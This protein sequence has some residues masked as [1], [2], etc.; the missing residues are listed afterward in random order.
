MAAPTGFVVFMSPVPV[1][2]QESLSK[3]L[4]PLL[5][6]LGIVDWDCSKG[7]DKKFAFLTFLS[8]EDGL[9]FLRQHGQRP[10]PGSSSRA[11]PNLRLLDRP[12]YCK[13]GDK[14]PDSLVVRVLLK[15]AHDRKRAREDTDQ[16]SSN[17]PVV[18]LKIAGISCG[19]YD[20][21]DGNLE[22]IQDVKWSV[23]EAAA[24]FS[25]DTLV[26]TFTTSRV[27]RRVEFAYRT[28]HEI[29]V[30]DRPPC[31]LLTLWE[32]PRMF[33]ELF[34]PGQF[35]HGAVRRK[36]VNSMCDDSSDHEAVVGQSAVYCITLEWEQLVSNLARLKRFEHLNFT[37]CC[38]PI[39]AIAH[40]PMLAGLRS[41]KATLDQ[42]S[43]VMPFDI[44]FQLQALVNNGYVLPHTAEKLLR[45][46]FDHAHRTAPAR[47]CE[48]KSD[49]SYPI[50][51]ES[52]KK[53]FS[54]MPF[55]GP[56]AEAKMFEVDEIWSWLEAN[57]KDFRK[58]L[59]RN[60]LSERARQNLTMI[61]RVQV[62]PSR[63]ILTGPEPEAKNRIL[64]KFP[65]HTDYFTRV[66]FCD[67]DGQDV[68]YNPRVSLDLVYD[69]FTKVLSD[70]FPIA[71]RL[72]KYL[73]YSHSSLR[74]HAAWH[75]AVFVDDDG[76]LQSYLSVIKDLGN[77]EGIRSP[78]KWKG[79]RAEAYSYYHTGAARIGQAFSE[80]PSAVDLVAVNAQ[81][82]AIPDVESPD[83]RRVFSD[84]VGT[85]SR[86]LLE[87]IHD[88]MPNKS[89]SATC[90]QI[91]WAGAKG[92]LSLD[93]TLSGKLM[94]IRPSMMKF[95]SLDVRYLEICDAA[96]KPIPLVLN[97]QMIKILEDMGCPAEWF[98]RAQN[99]ELDRLKRVTMSTRNTATFLRRQKIAEQIPLHTLLRRLDR[100]GFDYKQDR[101]LCSVVETVVLREVRLLKHKSRIPIEQGVTLFGVMDEFGFLE[102]DD[103]YVTLDDSPGR[104]CPVLHNRLV[105]ITRSPALHPGDIQIRRAVVPPPHH[106]LC[107]LSNCV[108]FSQKGERDLPSQLSGG[109][110]DGDIYNIIWDAFAV[111]GCRYEYPPADYPR[112]TALDI[113]RP[114]EQKDIIDNFVGF[115]K[116]DRLGF[117]ATRHVILADYHDA[118]TRHSDCLKLAEM[119]STAVDYS[120]TGIPVDMSEMSQ[121]YNLR[122]RPDFLAPAPP[123]IIMDRSD[124]CFE[125]PTAQSSQEDEDDDSGPKHKYYMSEKVLGTLYRAIDE[126]R[127]W[128]DNIHLTIKRSGISLWDEVLDYVHDQCSQL[129]QV[130]WRN[131][132]DEA[133]SIRQAYEDMI[134]SA[135]I[136]FS[137]HASK[138][139]TELEVFTGAIHNRTGIQTRRQRDTS[140]RLKDEFDRIT[141]WVNGLMRGQEPGELA[142]EGD[143]DDD[144]NDNDNDEVEGD[145]S[146]N[147]GHGEEEH[148]HDHDHVGPG[149]M[150]MQQNNKR[151]TALERSVACLSVGLRDLEEP[152]GGQFRAGSSGRFDSFKV[153]AAHN[154]LRE[155]EAETRRRES[156]VDEGF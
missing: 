96:N 23:L 50:S 100:L 63:I 30:S 139:I 80:T 21:P 94:R 120:K 6:S 152:G 148:D 135:T 151:C 99:R 4:S 145:R 81:Y 93:D 86:D 104:P 40:C 114:V 9:R 97:R 95:Q 66:Q 127:I 136:D 106:P 117:I 38:V 155:L 26:V 79:R 13:E 12:V 84:G 110:L 143:G 48:S 25:R 137:E 7:K 51:A 15:Q 39:N 133:W 122:A 65:R 113:G 45:R 22:Y 52:L 17:T 24:K 77:F 76:K 91:R 82:G 37:N 55:P 49:N 126:K 14:A 53:L 153:I 98:I 154:A 33:E 56:H 10:V 119:H 111:D 108:V 68:R 124:I 74:S 131:A 121:M 43:P 78:A 118:G 132:L 107:S 36:R 70:G 1:M 146:G 67:E 8:R 34:A 142:D 3:Q 102:E 31:L 11:M 27:R 87:A 18:T 58:G 19:H 156:V 105:I 69:R 101:F 147:G 64:R 57:E 115:M 42:F 46:L 116:T 123:A 85:I 28:I 90:F 129:G 128:R 2:T 89:K 103:V 54:Q 41:F 62:T 5:D 20:Y 16:P 61:H 141:R 59:F 125:P 83:G 112:A 44:L 32:P 47:A 71:G 144:D 88:I 149:D 134:W 130:Q 109:D 73:G 35:S 29:V 75:M 60:L 150:H 92:M 138:A 140:T 72:Y